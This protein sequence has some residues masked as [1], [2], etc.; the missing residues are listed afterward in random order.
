MSALSSHSF[1]I[2]VTGGVF[3]KLIPPNSVIPISDQEGLGGKMVSIRRKSDNFNCTLSGKA[4][5]GFNFP[6]HTGSDPTYPKNRFHHHPC[7]TFG[8]HEES[9]FTSIP[10]L[11]NDSR[12]N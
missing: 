6:K 5:V 2:E 3:I 9:Q 8:K 11:P 12:S 7:V 1:G 10:G 4:T